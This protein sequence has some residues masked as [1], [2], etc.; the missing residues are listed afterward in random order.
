MCDIIQV[1]A[2][3]G[4]RVFNAYS[5]PYRPIDPGASRVTGLTVSN[6][7]LFLRGRRLYTIPLIEALTSFIAF[8]RSFP[9]P[10][11]LAAHNAECFDAVVL[12]RVL[13]QNYLLQEMQ[14][15]LT[16]FLDTLLLGKRL[17]PGMISYTQK[18]LVHYFLGENYNAHNAVDDARM[19]QE[20]Y[21]EWRPK[22]QDV[23]SSMF[24]KKAE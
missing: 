11:I 6:G 13:E 21:Y 5:L 4:Q 8:L 15:V 9:N 1:S 18:S 24:Y 14:P 16:G 2:I 12:L 7:R 23:W 3:C 20:L 10:V 22:F 17:F 19:L